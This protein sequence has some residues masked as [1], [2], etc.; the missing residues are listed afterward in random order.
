[1]PLLSIFVL[2]GLVVATVV[3]LVGVVTAA[4]H[5]RWG[6]LLA[7]PLFLVGL[8]V[9]VMCLS[10]QRA[11]EQVAVAATTSPILPAIH[12]IPNVPGAPGVPGVR[13][14]VAEVASDAELEAIAGAAPKIN[15][16]EAVDEPMLNEDS[17]RPDWIENP[18]DWHQSVLTTDP[19]A[20]VDTCKAFARKQL[21][22]AVGERAEIALD[23]LG[24]DSQA[25]IAEIEERFVEDRYLEKREVSVGEVY[26]MHTLVSFDDESITW[27]KEQGTEWRRA[28]RREAS[29]QNIALGGGGVLAF[30][31]LLHGFLRGGKRSS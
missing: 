22:G 26:L 1:M 27:L 8:V 25:A 9:A 24:D 13:F 10:Y 31:A 4:Q 21:L 30:V 29:V 14:A 12:G 7:I 5:K 20:T 23:A 2:F 3:T 11:S 17:S 6:I 18:T 15:L 19:Y 16:D 28:A